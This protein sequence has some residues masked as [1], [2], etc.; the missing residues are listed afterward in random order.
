MSD[1]TQKTPF[2]ADFDRRASET[3]IESTRFVRKA[4]DM[5]DF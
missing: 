2:V 5:P 1:N 3:V 4:L